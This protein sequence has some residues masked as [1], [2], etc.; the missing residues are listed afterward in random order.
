MC[1][2]HWY[3]TFCTVLQLNCTAFNQSDWNYFFMYIIRV[4]I[5]WCDREKKLSY[6]HGQ[7][8]SLFKHAQNKD[9][10]EIQSTR[11]PPLPPPHTHC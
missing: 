8:M 2:L 3:Y 9:S 1:N 10:H 7:I 11:G 6:N 5:P 4:K